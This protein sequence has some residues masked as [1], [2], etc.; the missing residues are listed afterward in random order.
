MEVSKLDLRDVTEGEKEGKQKTRGSAEGLSLGGALARVNVGCGP[1]EERV[2]LTG[3]HAV[4]DIY[5]ENC[6]TTLG[7]KYSSP[8]RSYTSTR[9]EDKVIKDCV[10]VLL[11]GAEKWGSADNRV[12]LF[13]AKAFWRFAERKPSK[14]CPRAP[15]MIP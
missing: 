14:D 7:W 9:M 6:K 11:G 2:L 8:L 12:D 5:C 15:G 4:A 3:L 1:A 10:C 13:E